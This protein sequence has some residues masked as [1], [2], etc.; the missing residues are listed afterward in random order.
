MNYFREHKK[1]A[2]VLLLLFFVSIGIGVAA[3]YFLSHPS[4]KNALES[5]SEPVENKVM[6]FLLLGVD[7]RDDDVG[8]SDTILILSINPATRKAELISVPRDS[9]V[10]IPLHGETK[11]NHSFAYGGV[12]LTKQMVE[13]T[14]GIHIDNYFVFNFKG[15]RNVID[16]IDGVDLDVDKDMYYRDDWDDNGGLLINLKKG[17]QH[18][19]SE[20]S[21]EYVR[22][23]D[24][25]GD[26]GR[27]KR[28]QKFLKAV[29]DKLLSVENI[30]R[31]P[32][33][34]SS[35][36]RNIDTDLAFADCMKLVSVMKNV[37]N[38]EIH[39][40]TLPGTPKMI[41]DL[42]YWVIDSKKMKD[43][44]EAAN[45]FLMNKE[46]LAK[47]EDTNTSADNSDEDDDGL[48]KDRDMID[49]NVVSW[50]KDVSPKSKEELEKIKR[51]E[52][53]EREDE[54][55]FQKAMEYEANASRE[56]ESPQNVIQKSVDTRP[57]ITVVNAS[58][59]DS[60]SE[61]VASALEAQG[62]KVNVINSSSTSASS[63]AMVRDKDTA[64]RIKDAGLDI[65]VTNKPNGNNDTIILGKN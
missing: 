2:V 17:Q 65:P 63:S 37:Q 48:F 53:E 51:A 22:Y 44:L 31:L 64:E 36:Y 42:S 30:P 56:P 33:I 29:A 55:A 13:K 6:N 58:G 49:I 9:R 21:I 18:L 7:Q 35:I 4:Q 34:L 10:P 28:Q 11:I 23:R 20:K 54:R 41:N 12:Q 32:S 25:E 46:I 61:R 45:D 3:N 57:S 14:V 62:F 27:V 26:I 16:T 40:M 43:E 38:L 15:F 59:D 19:D 8:R 39:S 1:Q 24:T 52:M 5:S 47:K 50:E 60:A